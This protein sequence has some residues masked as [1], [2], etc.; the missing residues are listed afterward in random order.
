MWG[1]KP[2]WMAVL[3]IAFIFICTTAGS[4]MVF[5]F[6]H[7][8]NEKAK[9]I[10]LGFAAGVMIAA[11]VWGLLNPAIQ[12]AED[13]GNIGWIPAAFGFLAG[14][15]F[16][17][18]MDLLLP[19]LHIGGD[20]P[21]GLKSSWNRTTML[22]FAVGIHNI[23]EGLAV[24]FAFGLA[25]KTATVPALAAAVGLAIGIGLQN[26]PEGA[27]VSLP[28][29]NENLSTRKSFWLGTLTGVLEPV[30]AVI[31]L[32]LSAALAS[33][34]PWFLAFA[35]GAMMYVVVEE[36]IPEAHLGEHSNAGT[37]AVMI[38]FVLMMI[39]DVALG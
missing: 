19:H 28:L 24:G 23:P 11:S 9:K 3:G 22:V 12:Q 8:M 10:F 25:F 20:R 26:F 30:A 5:F 27:A 29:R 33:I 21:E 4:A 18:M 7:E 34:M 38:G 39:L 31:G 14:G 1:I 35:A 16:L 15:A 36:L 13:T 6:K 37:I 2:E 32:L 17:L